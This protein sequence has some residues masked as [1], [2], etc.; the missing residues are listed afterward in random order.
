MAGQHKHLLE[1]RLA[2]P[3][4]MR[5]EDLTTARRIRRRDGGT[6][7]LAVAPKEPERPS[8][9]MTIQG[10]HR[11]CLFQ[12]CLPVAYRTRHCIAQQEKQP[13]PHHVVERVSRGDRIRIYRHR[14]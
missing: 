1:P 7:G 12:D 2:D 8:I 3:A 9:L 13:V 6:H 14:P 4:H 11:R 5:Q 10:I